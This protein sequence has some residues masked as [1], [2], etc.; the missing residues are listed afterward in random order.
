[1]GI[2]EP[3]NIDKYLQ[4]AFDHIKPKLYYYATF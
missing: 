3:Y 2:N 4:Y 1:M